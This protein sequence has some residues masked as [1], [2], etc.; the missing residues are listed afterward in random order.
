LAYHRHDLLASVEPQDQVS[1]TSPF[2]SASFAFSF[3]PSSHLNLMKTTMTKK[4]GED[5]REACVE[6]PWV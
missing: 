5:Q 4:A 3:A 1:A 6:Q 2:A